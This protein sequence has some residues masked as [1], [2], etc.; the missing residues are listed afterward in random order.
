MLYPKLCKKEI[1]IFSG[2]KKVKRDS[3]ETKPSCKQ[4][5]NTPPTY[6]SSGSDNP[7]PVLQNVPMTPPSNCPTLRNLLTKPS[8]QQ[9]VSVTPSQVF[10]NYPDSQGYTASSESHGPI[11]TGLLP[12][13]VSDMSS[14]SKQ[15]VQGSQSASCSQLNPSSATLTSQHGG[16]ASDSNARFMQY[17]SQAQ[18]P[19]AELIQAHDETF[20][21]MLQGENISNQHQ[22]SF[23]QNPHANMAETTGNPQDCFP[24]NT[25]LFQAPSEQYDPNIQQLDPVYEDFIVNY[26]IQHIFPKLPLIEKEKLLV[27]LQDGVTPQNDTKQCQVQSP[28]SEDMVTS[29]SSG[30]LPIK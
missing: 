6:G 30:L 9:P 27:Q 21:R 22:F 16:V 14:A 3:T 20:I 29:S 18:G 10:H 12:T 11:Q 26:V 2:S 13:F 8:T 15:N 1:Y 7:F 24:D 23:F 19:Q 17:N 28:T 4:M 25:G 5:P